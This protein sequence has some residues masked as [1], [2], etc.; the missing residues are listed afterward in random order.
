MR[1]VN[2]EMSKE[3]VKEAL[4]IN[5]GTIVLENLHRWAFAQLQTFIE[6]KAQTQGLGVMYINPAYSS[7][8]CSSCAALGE[9]LK[10]RFTCSSCGNQQHSDL[11]ASR[12]L[13]RFALSADRATCAVDRTHVAV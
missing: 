3:I 1:H 2:H 11:N 13:C 7:Q 12:N 5:A 10:H 4:K 6:Y 8:L 9:R